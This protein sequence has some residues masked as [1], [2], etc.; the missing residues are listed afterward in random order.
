MSDCHVI[1]QLD[2]NRYCVYS[3]SNH[4]NKLLIDLFLPFYIVE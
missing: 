4:F 2:N 1:A 3:I